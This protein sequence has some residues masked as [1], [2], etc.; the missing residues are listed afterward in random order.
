MAKNILLI[1]D[2]HSLTNSWQQQFV[3]KGFQIQTTDWESA[4]RG[5]KRDRPDLIIIDIARPINVCL[6]HCRELQRQTSAPVLLLTENGPRVSLDQGIE[7][8]A[9]PTRFASLWRRVEAALERA[10]AWEKDRFLQVGPVCLDTK[11]HILIKE[12]KQHK[13]APKLFALLRLFMNNAGQVLS[14]EEIMKEVWATDYMGD[15]GTLYVHIRWLRRV[16]ED[17]PAKPTV[18]RTVR[19]LGY[20]FDAP[21]AQDNRG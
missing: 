12:G 19:G 6:M 3:R 8:L 17:D 20:R 11:E 18:L 21:R 2:S 4:L 7:M 5:A 15:T 14:R 1:Q 10:Q 13:L 9:R 16:I